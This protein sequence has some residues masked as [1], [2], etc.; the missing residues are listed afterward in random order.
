MGRS[1]TSIHA[2]IWR[3]IRVSTAVISL[4]LLIVIRA[5]ESAF[6]SSGGAAGMST[7]VA[8]LKNP[9]I[10]ALYGRANSLGSAG[11]FVSWK[12]GMYMALA[13]ALW[14]CSQ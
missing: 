11:A 5:G 4:L 2:L 1:R 14:I 8:L 10:S 13:A 9:A 7:F 6:Y 12:M 3:Q